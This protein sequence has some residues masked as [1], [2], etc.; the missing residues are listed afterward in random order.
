MQQA[1]AQSIAKSFVTARR[2]AGNLP[3]YPGAIP[4]TL[5]VAYAIQDA[6]IADFFE[7]V[8]GWKVGRIWPPDSV[9]FGA[10]RLA[11]PIFASLV[12][13]QNGSGV[14]VGRVFSGGFG[15]A[16]AEFL[17]HVGSAPDPAQRSFSTAE[18]AA[19]IDRVHVGIE[20]ASSPLPS[21]NALGPA[22]TVSDFG[23]NNG[24]I[25][26]PEIADWQD[27]DF[28][29]WTVT[30]LIDGVEAGSGNARDFPEGPLGAASFLFAH[31]ADRGIALPAGTWISSG[32]VSGVHPVAA[33]QRVEARFGTGLN[34]H[35]TVEPASSKGEAE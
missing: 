23:N 27:S 16:E 24:L 22:V 12:Q 10:E 1:E 13:R 26:G 30:T 20:I 4:E 34:M 29:E 9:R 18:A 2:A 15:A 14:S 33:N 8:A 7:P 17:L 31:M 6:A 35:C 3:S 19:L 25:I 32:A 11:G 5:A 28:A 21:I